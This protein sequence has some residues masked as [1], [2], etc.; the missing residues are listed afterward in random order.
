VSL[1]SR[2]E[3]LSDC[4][5]LIQFLSDQLENAHKR[6]AALSSRPSVQSSEK[7]SYQSDEESIRGTPVVKNAEP[8]NTPPEGSPR[9][10]VSLESSIG[11]HFDE[12]DHDVIDEKTGV[13]SA[14]KLEDPF[15]PI[16]EIHIPFKLEHPPKTIGRR[17]DPT[18]PTAQI[19]RRMS[20]YND[21]QQSQIPSGHS[22]KAIERNKRPF[23][24]NPKPTVSN[25]F[26]V[27]PETPKA[28]HPPTPDNPS[29]P[30]KSQ[31][32]RAPLTFRGR[33][34][35]SKSDLRNLR[36]AGSPEPPPKSVVKNNSFIRFWK[37]KSSPPL[38]RSQEAKKP[39]TNEN[40]NYPPTPEKSPKP[41]FRQPTNFTVPRESDKHSRH[42]RINS[43]FLSAPRPSPAVIAST[44][45]PEWQ[46]NVGRQV[47]EMVQ[48]WEEETSRRTDNIVSCSNYVAAKRLSNTNFKDV[49]TS[50]SAVSAA[51]DAWSAKLDAA[52]VSRAASLRS[53]ERRERID[54]LAPR[55][56]E[57][58]RKLG[59][60]NVS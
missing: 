5:A 46:R 16:K 41:E 17:F 48:H 12:E 3:E 42:P 19:R 8:V 50:R 2:D 18:S 35:R 56:D 57:L 9:S 24:G 22:S 53:I 43:V 29:I 60:K 44:P 11:S 23:K 15:D 49:S 21:D 34:F 7:S 25:V 1:K 54:K 28:E 59:L 38:K 4:K 27:D 37:S 31:D 36:P 26:K 55:R 45:N 33:I 58:A 51:K 52:S 6:I 30:M 32:Q 40:F 14:T 10:L 39:A 47:T 20:L 13:R